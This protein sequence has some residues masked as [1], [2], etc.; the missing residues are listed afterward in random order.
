MTGSAVLGS[1]EAPP[2]ASRRGLVGLGC[3]MRSLGTAPRACGPRRKETPPS[4]HSGRR[5]HRP[6][7]RPL[8]S[9]FLPGFPSCPPASPP[10]LPRTQMVVETASFI[11]GSVTQPS[12]ASSARRLPRPP[13]LLPHGRAEGPGGSARTPHPVCPEAWPTLRRPP[14]SCLLASAPTVNSRGTQCPGAPHRVLG[15]G[16]GRALVWCQ[17]ESW[18]QELSVASTSLWLVAGPESQVG[19]LPP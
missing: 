14:I 18:V 12:A 19:N 4:P 9:R 13:S 11:L 1:P 2:E 8:P 10:P 5:R 15:G 17:A 16:H 7:S 3:A 6:C